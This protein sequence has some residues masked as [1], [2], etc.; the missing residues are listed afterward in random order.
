MVSKST[1]F[2]TDFFFVGIL[3]LGKITDGADNNDN[4]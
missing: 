4:R 1:L 2:N 3:K